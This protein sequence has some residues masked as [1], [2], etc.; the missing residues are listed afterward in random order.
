MIGLEVLFIKLGNYFMNI[1]AEVSFMD[2]ISYTGY[3]FV[4][5][6]IV[7]LTKF[8]FGAWSKFFVYLYCFLAF[9]FF[10]VF[11]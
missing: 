11:D 4:P 3:Q 10:T 1:S 9:G 5:I 6:C 7:L 8:T 2:L